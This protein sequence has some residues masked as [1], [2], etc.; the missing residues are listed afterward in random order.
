MSLKRKISRTGAWLQWYSACLASAKSEV[1][2]TVLKKEKEQ[3]FRQII[4]SYIQVAKQC[5]DH[6]LIF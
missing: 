6:I 3:N 1:Q 2:T 5:F 4:I